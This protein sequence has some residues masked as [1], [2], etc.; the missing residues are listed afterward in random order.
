MPLGVTVKVYDEPFV[1]PVTVQLCEPAAGGV[2]VFTIEQLPL[3][4]PLTTY[5]VATPSAVKVTLIAPE[6]AFATV[7]VAMAFVAVIAA[8]RADTVEVVLLPVGF[9]ENSYDEVFV[10]PLTVQLC[11]PVGA[12]VVFATTQVFPATL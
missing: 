3:G 11:V 8:D 2:V 4:E 10:S 9:T 7:G 12:V 1:S 6:P 5:D